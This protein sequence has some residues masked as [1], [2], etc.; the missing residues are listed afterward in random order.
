MTDGPEGDAGAGN[1]EGAVPGDEVW[2]EADDEVST[3]G[4]K[5]LILLLYAVVVSIA[6]LTGFLIGALGIRGLRPVTFLGLVTFQPTATGLAA[7]G[8]LTMGLGLGVM[9]A[10]VVYVSNEYVDEEA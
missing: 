7:Y 8:M 6:G 3:L 9:L 1:R 4:G 5:R 10:L 2:D